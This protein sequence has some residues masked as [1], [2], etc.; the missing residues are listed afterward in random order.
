MPLKKGSSRATISSNIDE[1]INAGHPDGH[2]QAAAI[3]FKV[4]GKSRKMTK[5]TNP[6]IQGS[7]NISQLGQSPG[8]ACP[9][10]MPFLRKQGFVKSK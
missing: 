7:S 2:G 3:A 6:I 1:L 8:G 10:G 5:K 9:T 4:A